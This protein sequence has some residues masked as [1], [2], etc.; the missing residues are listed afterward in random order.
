M[1]FTRRTPNVLDP[2]RSASASSRTM[3]ARVRACVPSLYDIP[4][5]WIARG[6]PSLLRF[7]ATARDTCG[8]LSCGP[9]DGPAPAVAVAAVALPPGPV[10]SLLWASMRTDRFR[11]AREGL[12]ERLVRRERTVGS[13]EVPL[14]GR[15]EDS[16][17][18]WRERWV[19]SSS[20][21]RRATV[22]N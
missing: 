3:D 9:L 22:P 14:L 10:P 6:L 5:S 21:I 1:L 4:L 11:T 15:M 18:A 12:L 8:L 19:L 17:S 2:G 16:S 13:P 20:T 7:R